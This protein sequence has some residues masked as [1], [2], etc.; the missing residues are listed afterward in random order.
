MAH[1][2]VVDGLEKNITSSVALLIGVSGFVTW[3]GKR[4][5]VS[6]VSANFD[7]KDAYIYLKEDLDFEIVQN[8]P[9]LDSIAI[10]SI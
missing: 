7:S 1:K 10:Q 3:N 2:L 4:Y 9:D 8:H 6:E 5:V